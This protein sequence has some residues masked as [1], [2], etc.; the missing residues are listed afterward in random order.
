VALRVPVWK[1][2]FGDL[3][4]DRFGKL[5]AALS[6]YAVGDR[7]LRP[8]DRVEVEGGVLGRRTVTMA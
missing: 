1:R 5:G 4:L 8:G 3:F 2:R 7:F 6:A